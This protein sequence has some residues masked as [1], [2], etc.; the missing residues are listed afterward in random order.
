MQV[1]A[2]ASLPYRPITLS[3]HTG[4]QDEAGLLI[5]NGEQVETIV[6][7]ESGA[8]RTDVGQQPAGSGG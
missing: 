1:L 3:P 8:G 6:C 5:I 4:S 7:M 2:P